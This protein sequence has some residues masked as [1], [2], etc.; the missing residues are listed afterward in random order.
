MRL[1]IA[2]VMGTLV[3]SIIL[4]ILASPR[5]SGGLREL[6]VME[7]REGEYLCRFVLVAPSK[8]SYTIY[9]NNLEN[10]TY[11]ITLIPVGG[12]EVRAI[13]SPGEKG[14]I[15]TI[16]VKSPGA[17]MLEAR[18]SGG[19]PAFCPLTIAASSG[20]GKWYFIYA[21][22]AALL[23]VPGYI[24]LGATTSRWN[25]YWL[26][27]YAGSLLVP[28]LAFSIGRPRAGAYP[29]VAFSFSY[30]TSLTM[31]AKKGIVSSVLMLAAI[32][33]SL[34]SYYP[35][36]GQW[37]ASESLLGGWGV[38][39]S[40]KRAL[41]Y[42]AG[43]AISYAASLLGYAAASGALDGALVSHDL[44]VLLVFIARDT[45]CIGIIAAGSALLFSGLSMAT[46][47][48]LL[49]L[50]LGV[51]LFALVITAP[52]TL[53]T[54]SLEISDAGISIGL[55]LSKRMPSAVLWSLRNAGIALLLYLYG[56]ARR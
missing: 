17:T 26:P 34:S 2:L 6:P 48:P 42:S 45:V 32:G 20:P 11:Y 28:L 50:V 46:R 44:G 31:M 19:E 16:E 9:Y 41:L 15:S 23:L 3:L 33:G 49:A 8:S 40:I 36:A 21:G 13:A 51:V 12:Q 10:N 4:G 47:S 38:I 39:P 54:G 5:E 37:E 24:L 22:A 7:Q 18:I 52:C 29:A 30:Y 14:I 56:W 25:R 35:R 53:G 55:D 43:L 27:L 1:G